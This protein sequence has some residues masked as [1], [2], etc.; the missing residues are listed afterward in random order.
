MLRTSLLISLC[1]AAAAGAANLRGEWPPLEY[2]PYLVCSFDQNAVFCSSNDDCAGVQY[3]NRGGAPCTEKS[4]CAECFCCTY[5]YYG[6]Q[7]QPC[8]GEEEEEQEKADEAAEAAAAARRSPRFQV[9]EA[10]KEPSPPPST[11]APPGKFGV[12]ADPGVDENYGYPYTVGGLIVEG[13]FNY[14]NGPT[15]WPDGGGFGA[16]GIV[17][18]APSGY[19]KDADC[20]AVPDDSPLKPLEGEGAVKPF[21]L[22]SA[23]TPL[24]LCMLSCNKTAVALGVVADP[25]AAGGITDPSISPM[26]CYDLGESMAPGPDMGVCGYNCTVLHMGVEG[27]AAPCTQEDM[28]GGNWDDCGLYCDSTTFPGAAAE[29]ARGTEAAIPP[30]PLRP[31][32]K[33]D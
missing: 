10:R 20:P 31:L 33:R 32:K 26:G 30:R 29:A 7:C 25:C 8:G 13:P 24:D 1:L 22:F 19:R 2:N 6:D 5:T 9:V 27:A 18:V 11:T 3:A 23:Q 16:Y 28:D 4:R 14:T 15:V 12:G 21:S 17:A